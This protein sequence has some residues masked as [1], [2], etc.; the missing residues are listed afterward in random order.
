M[1]DP[2]SRISKGVSLLR[3]A[4][5]KKDAKSF[6]SYIKH[7]ER[8]G[9]CSN[10]SVLAAVSECPIWI[11]REAAVAVRIKLQGNYILLGVDYSWN[12]LAEMLGSSVDVAS[13]ED[14]RNILK[15]RVIAVLASPPP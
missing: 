11:L 7:F 5:E 13:L 4:V 14:A 1:S 15:G 3:E 12:A 2:S 9:Q 8:L 6:R 10:T